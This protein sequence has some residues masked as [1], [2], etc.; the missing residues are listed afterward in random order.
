[1]SVASTRCIAALRLRVPESA[2]LISSSVERRRASRA[3]V[4]ASAPDLAAGMAGLLHY[5]AVETG[6]LHEHTSSATWEDTFT[7]LHV[8]GPAAGKLE[9]SRKSGLNCNNAAN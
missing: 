7:R 8:S 3:A 6:S 2:W 4:V 9:A 1:M 5:S